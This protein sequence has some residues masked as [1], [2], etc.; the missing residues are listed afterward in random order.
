M[1]W[2]RKEREENWRQEEKMDYG[3]GGMQEEGK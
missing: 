3:P 2:K 1:E